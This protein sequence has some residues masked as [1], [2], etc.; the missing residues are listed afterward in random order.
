[1][2]C[3]VAKVCGNLFSGVEKTLNEDDFCTNN[4]SREENLE[5]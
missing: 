3:V 1:M 2:V 5:D 4:R